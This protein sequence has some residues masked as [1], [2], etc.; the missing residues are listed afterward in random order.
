MIFVYPVG[1]P[2]MYF[3]ML[4]KHREML[5]NEQAMDR[6]AANEYPTLGHLKFL[7]DSYKARYYY[8]EVIEVFRRL[9]LASVIGLLDSSSTSASVMGLIICV[10]SNWVFME[11]KPYKDLGDSNI[12]IVFS[13]SLTLF[14]VAALIIK[15]EETG[16]LGISHQELGI[17]LSIILGIGPFGLVI[18]TLM[19]VS[20]SSCRT[21]KALVIRGIYGE[22][23]KEKSASDAEEKIIEDNIA[24][25]E[26]GMSAE[27]RHEAEQAPVSKLEVGKEML[28]LSKTKEQVEEASSKVHGLWSDDSQLLL[29]GSR[30]R[31]RTQTPFTTSRSDSIE[32][33]FSS[34]ATTEGVTRFLPA[35]PPDNGAI[36]FLS[37]SRNDHT[38]ES[39]SARP[40]PR[41]VFLRRTLRKS[42]SDDSFTSLADSKES[43]Q[44]SLHGG[45]ARSVA[46]GVIK[47]RVAFSR[48]ASQDNSTFVIAK[49]SNRD[50]TPS[51]QT[52]VKK[53]I[54]ERAIDST[55][56]DIEL[57][58]LKI[59]TGEVGS[60]SSDFFTSSMEQNDEK[61]EGRLRT[62]SVD[63][64]V[65][66]LL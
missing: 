61:R 36:G 54:R 43:P 5:S 15:S 25:G 17:V 3:A 35:T 49:S 21:L 53:G 27:I 56:P 50:K 66:L 1:I 7:V 38:H 20:A 14:F 11:C 42:A 51:R 65:S 48:S 45:R 9:L 40:I 33:Q 26:V 37:E 47:P 44:G 32:S 19:G 24:E 23:S 29:K 55:E 46:R 52:M 16:T 28:D 12:A 64:P 59:T 10:A 13:H 2:A 39:S 34:E 22:R 63:R 57:P 8:F 6:E 18:A 62:A 30:F 41:H 60:S 4:F 58:I 31:K